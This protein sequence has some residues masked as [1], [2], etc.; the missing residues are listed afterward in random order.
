M[1]LESAGILPYKINSVT[2]LIEV[3][4][5]HPGGPY[6]VTKDTGAWD[7]FKGLVEGTET[8]TNAARR[9]F[10]EE[11]GLEAP[12]VLIPLGTVLKKSGKLVWAWAAQV[13]ID[14]TQTK[15]NLCEGIWPPKSGIIERWPEI[16]RV[17]WFDIKVA[18][19]KINKDQ[20]PFLMR[21]AHA[22]I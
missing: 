12:D 16:D 8:H 22:L 6:W 2:N 18:C 4:L 9:E 10:Y 7:I 1:P 17:E 11:T 13:D 19:D 20:V 15:S 21:L 5:G 3:C 14:P